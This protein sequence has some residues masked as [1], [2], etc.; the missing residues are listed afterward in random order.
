MKKIIFLNLIC[1]LFCF[2]CT[3]DDDVSIDYTY[4][5][6]SLINVSGS[7]AGIDQDIEEGDIIWTFNASENTVTVV[8]TTT[9]EDITDFLDSGT[10]N[11]SYINNNAET[12][13][14]SESLVI[15]N[16]DF[17]CVT[18]EGNTMRLSNTW[19]DGY[20]LTFVK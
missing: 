17:G 16:I 5:S 7:L 3:Q 9:D 15:D 12:E 14:C 18:I 2:A 13:L 10:Y 20:Q 6:W 11:Y 4:D 1:V 8:N 19:L